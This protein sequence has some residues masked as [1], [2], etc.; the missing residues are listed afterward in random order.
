MRKRGFTLIELM[1]VVAIIAIIAAVAIPG[2]L[3]SRIG[4]NEASAQ[5]SLKSI[6]TGQEQFKSANCVDQNSNGVG[7]YGFLEELG[8]VEQCRSAGAAL[9]GATYTA[10]PY[11]PRILGTANATGDAS[12]AGYFI[13]CFLP[14]TNLTAVKLH[15]GAYVATDFPLGEASY[16][17]YAWP[18]AAGRSGVRTFVIDP[19]GQPYSHANS[20][21]TYSGANAIPAAQYD[22]AFE[23]ATTGWGDGYIEGG[24]AGKTGHATDTWVPTG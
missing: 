18:Q 10:S 21:P 7:E 19:S 1:I 17:A 24:T 4:S 16:I 20:A 3:R 11:I 13:C 6:V 15:G 9:N 12:K 23:A 22:D 8:G 2:L 14:V 5:G